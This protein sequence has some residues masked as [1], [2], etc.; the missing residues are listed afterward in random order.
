MVSLCPPALVYLILSIIIII[1]VIFT[2]N[3]SP[4]SIIIKILFVVLWTVILNLICNHVNPTVSWILVILPYVFITFTVLF[5][6]EIIHKK[7]RDKKSN[8]KQVLDEMFNF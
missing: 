2:Y 3:Y 4:I 1:S 5:A 8:A 7:I 6:I